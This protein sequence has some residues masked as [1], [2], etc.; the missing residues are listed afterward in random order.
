MLHYKTKLKCSGNTLSTYHTIRKKT[1]LREKAEPKMKRENLQ[2]SLIYV[3]ESNSVG[4]IK[5]LAS[6]FP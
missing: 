6:W 1:Q 4:A 2:E 3:R 5:S